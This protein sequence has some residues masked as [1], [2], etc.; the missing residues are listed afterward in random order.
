MAEH[1]YKSSRAIQRVMKAVTVRD[2]D[3]GWNIVD[4]DLNMSP[5]YARISDNVYRADDGSMRVR[6][7]TKLFAELAVGKR[8]IAAD[9]HS[10][11]IVA[12]C[13]DGTMYKILGDGTSSLIWDD[14]RAAA[15]GANI[16]WGPTNYATFAFS[17]NQLIVMDGLDQPVTVDTT[18]AVE[19]LVD[20]VTQNNI[21]VPRAKFA[22]QCERYLCMAGDPNEPSTVFVGAIDATGTFY[23]LSDGV[24]VDLKSRVLKGSTDI[25]GLATFRGK[26]IVMF[27][28]CIIIGTLGQ[29][30]STTHVPAFDEPIENYGA[31][32]QRVLQ[33]LGDDL[34]FCDIDGVP[35]L[36]RAL[37]TG[38]INPARRS[39]LIDPDIVKRINALD[40]TSLRERCFSVYNKS[41]S[42]YMLM[43]PSDFTDAGTH[44]FYNYVYTSI[45]QLKINAW[46]RFRD[47]KWSAA[48][49]STLGNLFF[50]RDNQVYL[51]GNTN[52]AFFADYI[53]D[54]ETFSDGTTF[55]DGLGLS[56]ISDINTSGVPIR[57]I[58]EWPWADFGDR[59]AKKKLKYIQIDSQ[60]DGTFT[61]ELYVDNIVLVANTGEEFSDGTL[62]S[63]ETGWISEYEPRD[64][65]LSMPMVAGSYP[66]Y[67]NAPYGSSQ[68]GGGR[69]SIDERLYE[70][71]A[72]F[73]IGKLRLIG[74][75]MGDV[76]FVSVS[77]MH[78]S[79]SI[80][81]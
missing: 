36:E 12:V 11:F 25:I 8:I 44:E 14:A 29:Y 15:T 75:T 66:G 62:F 54:Q 61:A 7:G 38:S 31:I 37:F 74:E 10:N 23:P 53:G 57:F 59:T 68:Y 5:K 26:L 67:G 79:G 6:Y 78:T 72:D 42:Q 71:P 21:Y 77:F 27:E 19:Y 1:F 13:D 46:S 70:F 2:F 39:V 9:Y 69:P 4:N 58:W 28:Q 35:A 51:Y 48:C 3:G 34:L 41:E 63:D 24:N 52:Q 80:R 81:R 33:S 16:G 65:A 60:G 22:V 40:T 17:R 30:S 49:R 64:P 56:P 43:L 18:G 76:A 50:F 32:G 73:K 45:P 55:T 20:A 47:W